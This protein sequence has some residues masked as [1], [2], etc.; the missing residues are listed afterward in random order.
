MCHILEIEDTRKLEDI[1]DFIESRQ[2]E[3]A[4]KRGR[5][6]VVDKQI[7]ICTTCKR[8][9]EG[10][11]ERNHPAGFTIYPIGMIPSYGKK[12]KTCPT[13]TRRQEQK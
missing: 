2:F 4:E 10:V 8:A 13:C 9:W 1:T 11:N 3:K 7:K 12:K 6:V 5:K